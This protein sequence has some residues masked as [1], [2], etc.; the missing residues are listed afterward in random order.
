MGR[1]MRNAVRFVG[2]EGVKKGNLKKAVRT[3]H[4][5]IYIADWSS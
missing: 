2:D 3:L 5:S 4:F 1:M